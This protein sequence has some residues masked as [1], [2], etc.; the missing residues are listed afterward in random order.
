MKYSY[1]I[2]EYVH[3]MLKQHIE[4][5]DICVDATVGR[6]NDTE[7]L[8]RLVGESG[9][10]YGFD[11]QKDAIAATTD[12]MEK[13]GLINGTWLILDGHENMKNYVKEKISAITFNFGY[14]PGGDHN[15]STRSST[16]IKAI[17]EGLSLLKKDGIMSLCIYSGGDSGYE[18]KDSILSF[19]KS[20]DPKKYL[21][22]L[23]QYYN[24][25]NDPPIPAFVIKLK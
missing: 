14:L 12:R 22:I 23:S 1:Q 18:E 17:E 10:V 7:F 20:L 5:G 19:L 11:I 15:I 16:S 24:R 3:R 13:A 8:K 2:T 4:D 21:V 6:G 9:K 25:E